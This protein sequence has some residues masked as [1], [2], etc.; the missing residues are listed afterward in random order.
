[1]RHNRELSAVPSKSRNWRAVVK[2]FDTLLAEVMITN[3]GTALGGSAPLPF[4][5][6]TS[7][8]HVYFFFTN[9]VKITMRCPST[10]PS[11]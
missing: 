10:R 3:S 4:Y 1:M 11:I 7:R 9:S 2:P 8:P 6:K 5:S